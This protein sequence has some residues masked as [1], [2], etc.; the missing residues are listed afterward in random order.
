MVPARVAFGST[1]A[2]VM[3][4]F[5]DDPNSGIF[6]LYDSNSETFVSLVF[7]YQDSFNPYMFEHVMR[8]YNLQSLLDCKVAPAQVEKKPVQNQ[9]TS[10]SARR[11]AS[12]RRNREHHPTENRKRPFGEISTAA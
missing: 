7:E 11:R 5:P 6:T 1:G 9:V 12:R 4:V 2:I 8:N 3:T 10:R